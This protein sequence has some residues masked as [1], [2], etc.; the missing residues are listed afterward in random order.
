MTTM[1]GEDRRRLIE[2][3]LLDAGELTYAELVEEL[4]VSEMTVRRDV[5]T[6]ETKGV[7]RRI[8]GGAISASGKGT[9]PRF[10]ARVT[11]SAT[12]KR[13]IAEAVAGLLHPRETVILDGGSTV[14][15]LARAI[16]GRGL[17]LTVV[18]SS[19]LVGLT[20]ADEPETRLLLNGGLLRSGELTLVGPGATEAY[21]HYNA[22]TYVMGAAGVDAARGITDYHVEESRVKRAAL[23]AAD[24]VILAVDASKLGNVQLVNIAPLEAATVIVTDGPGDHPALVA[25]RAL[26]IEVVLCHPPEREQDPAASDQHTVDNEEQE[27]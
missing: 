23:E 2:L 7:L 16:R 1:S 20:L 5:E 9:E 17:G 25:A 19:L 4:G 10:S 3:R 8:L 26:G 6:L 12:E 18:T 24:R 27:A 21:R 11:R 14:L 13:H 15:A 22:D